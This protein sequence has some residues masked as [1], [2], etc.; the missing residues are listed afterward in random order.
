MSVPIALPLQTS[1]IVLAYPPG[2]Q[3]RVMPLA[4]VM[5]GGRLGYGYEGEPIRLTDPAASA[6]QHAKLRRTP[7]GLLVKD[8]EAGAI[9]PRR[10]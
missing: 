7:V 2:P 1:V 5:T 3:P 4:D 8:M 10:Y 9:A 6:G